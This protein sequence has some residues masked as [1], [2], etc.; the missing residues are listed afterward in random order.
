M[1]V[2]GYTN[3]GRKQNLGKSLLLQLMVHYSS[4]VGTFSASSPND[5][6]V[7]ITFSFYTF[8]MKTKNDP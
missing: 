2:H 4:S 3:P 1:A 7:K 5:C 8:E 6:D